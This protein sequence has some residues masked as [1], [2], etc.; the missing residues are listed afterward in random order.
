MLGGGREDCL[1]EVLGLHGAFF[2]VATATCTC[3]SRVHAC[4][5]AL[6]LRILPNRQA[7]GASARAAESLSSP[8]KDYWRGRTAVSNPLRA[9]VAVKPQTP[10]SPFSAPRAPAFPALP[11]SRAPDVWAERAQRWLPLLCTARRVRA[12]VGRR[13]APATGA[14]SG[15]S[16]CWHTCWFHNRHDWTGG[17]DGARTAGASSR[18]YRRAAPSAPV[19]FCMVH[20]VLAELIT[21]ILPPP[22]RIV[23]WREREGRRERE[24]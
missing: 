22:P 18:P 14:G 21:L 17:W 20:S 16:A 8:D 4:T 2:L 5:S 13:D 9:C 6:S 24:D 3:P 12:S 19:P 7:A 10:L 1:Q 11:L 23:E 15:G